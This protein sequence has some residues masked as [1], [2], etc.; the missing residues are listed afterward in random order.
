VNERISNS[1][2]KAEMNSQSPCGERL[3]KA[4]PSFRV[5]F[6]NRSHIKL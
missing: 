4:F 5:E 6:F 1:E 2:L 3:A